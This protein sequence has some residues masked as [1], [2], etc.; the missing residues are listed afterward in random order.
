MV[1]MQL[2]IPLFGGQP[3]FTYAV[4]DDPSLYLRSD[5][6]MFRHNPLH[7]GAVTNL[8]AQINQTL[9]NYT[10]GGLVESSP[11]I[12]EGRIYVG[13]NDFRIYSLEASTG[14]LVWSFETGDDVESSPAVVEGRVFVGS[15]DRTLYCLNA[16]SGVLLWSFEAADNVRASPTVVDGLVFVGS[17]DGNVYCLNASTGAPVWSYATEGRV[18]SSPAVAGGNVYVGSYDG[19]VYCLDASMG[20]QIWNYSTGGRVRSSPAVV[21]GRVFVGSEDGLVYSLNASSGVLFWS[22][23]TRRR[24]FSSPAV[25]ENHVYIGS[26]DGR[27]YCLNASTGGAVWNFTTGGG[28]ESSPAVDQER[29]FIGSNDGHVYCLNAS[30]G[31]PIWSYVTGGAVASSPAIADGLLFVGSHDGH[32][33]AL[34]R[35]DIILVPEDYPTM[36]EAIAAAYP[37]NTI[38]VAVGFYTESFV[39]DKP[40]L[41]IG[42][43]G[44]SPVFDG[45]GSGTAITL[46]AEASGT[47]VT[48]LALADWEQGIFFDGSTNNEV[49]SNVMTLNDV[50]LN[51]T[52]DSISNTIYAN[53][54][55][56]NEYGIIV[57]ESAN[58]IYHNNFI[59]NTVQVYVLAPVANAWDD[60]YPSGG[61]FWSNHISEDLFSGPSQDQPGSDGIWDTSYSVAE[62]NVDNYPL[63]KPH[64]GAHDVGILNV[65]ASKQLIGEGFN[66]YVNVELLNYGVG[67]DSCSVITYA[68][69][70][71]IVQSDLIIPVRVATTP[72]LVWDTTPL[73][74]YVN[75]TITAYA[76]LVAEEVETSDN[77]G[78]DGW[79]IVT[80]AGDVNADQL[81]DIFDLVKVAL[82][83]GEAVAEPLVWPLPDEDVNGDGVYDIFD[84]VVVAL[85]FGAFYA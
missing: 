10:T 21:E 76:A 28:V 34:G 78:T 80:I 32:V 63:T 60:G 58:T 65:A 49:Y 59:D 17:E 30:T 75:Y 24:V 66:L 74:K 52:A 43:Q 71:P 5:W 8:G 79:V 42:R 82:V 27:V 67:P 25:S 53:T 55:T 23:A 16:S 2:A 19:R 13:S 4:P 51:L 83:F 22:Y 84:L 41:I 73:T 11:A 54:I 12:A 40:L 70:V 47:V 20:A 64:T 68:N 18:R 72:S 37:G 36:Q 46:T 3:L 29:V 15:E 7:S 1:L 50:A 62:F 57:S 31:A 14:S 44:S 56:Q 48:G 45:G 38:S 85:N 69:G 26:L 81:V 39:I 77:G 61:N 9:W 33:Y 6:R 35:R